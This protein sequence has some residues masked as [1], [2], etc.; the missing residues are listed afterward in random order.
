MAERWVIE[1][2]TT[3][4]GAEQGREMGAGRPEFGGVAV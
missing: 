2:G 3:L 4:R 1:F